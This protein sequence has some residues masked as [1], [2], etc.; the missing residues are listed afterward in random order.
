MDHP[1]ISRMKSISC[2]YVWWQGL[3]ADIE[4]VAKSCLLFFQSS[5][6]LTSLPETSIF[7]FPSI[8]PGFT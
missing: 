3:E 4:V 2:R 7:G 1:G 8:G 6:L 5:H